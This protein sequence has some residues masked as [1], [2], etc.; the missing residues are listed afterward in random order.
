M[1]KLMF[2]NVIATTSWIVFEQVDFLK[3]QIRLF[4]ENLGVVMWNDIIAV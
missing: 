4:N 1:F 3:T 2:H